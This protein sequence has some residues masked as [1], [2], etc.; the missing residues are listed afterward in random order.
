MLNNNNNNNNYNI[1]NNNNLCN[2]QNLKLIGFITRKKVKKLY[3]NK[4]L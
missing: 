4:K 3:I 1:N 2:V